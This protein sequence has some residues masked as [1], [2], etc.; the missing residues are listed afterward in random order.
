MSKPAT[1]SDEAY[2]ALIAH[3]HRK[4]ESLSQIILRF[5][6][7]PIRT[8]GDLEKHLENLEGPVVVDYEALDRVRRRRQKGNRAD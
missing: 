7:R 6:P 1:L 2:A 8:F 4:S 5:V 3:K